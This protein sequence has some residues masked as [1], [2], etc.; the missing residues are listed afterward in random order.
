MLGFVAVESL[1]YI[2]V[3]TKTKQYTTLFGGHAINTVI[4]AEWIRVP[5]SYPYTS[6]RDHVKNMKLMQDFPIEV[7]HEE[8]N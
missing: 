3:A 2:V 1:A 8:E 5:L 4:E 7:R 6:N